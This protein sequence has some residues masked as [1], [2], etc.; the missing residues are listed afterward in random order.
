M[1]VLHMLSYCLQRYYQGINLVSLTFLLGRVKV[2]A[3]F[4][5]VITCTMRIVSNYLHESYW[6]MFLNNPVTKV[7]RTES[8]NLS[9]L[10]CA[11]NHAIH[12]K[13]Y[14]GIFHQP[15]PPPP[16]QSYQVCDVSYH[17]IHI[18]VTRGYFINHPYPPYRHQ[19]Y[20]ERG[21]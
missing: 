14:R 19:S 13:S 7:I 15:L 10:R 2:T 12:T 3:V 1:H 16:C 21:N 18:K 17:A 20:Q 6:G 9:G 5:W 8:H 4:M 11:S